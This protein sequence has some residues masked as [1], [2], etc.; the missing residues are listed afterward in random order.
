QTSDLIE[1]IIRK[2]RLT[3]A[4]L[5][6]VA[7]EELS[8]IVGSAATPLEPYLD[9]ILCQN[10]AASDFSIKDLMDAD[11]PV[12]LYYILPGTDIARLVPLTRMLII[13]MMRKLA[14]RMER[15]AS[16]A[17]KAP[18]RHRLLMMMD[19][20]PILG[21]IGEFQTSMAF[22]GGYG[23]KV[24]LIAQDLPQIMGAYGQYESI[25]GNC[26]IRIYFTPN[27]L[28]TA[29]PLS[30]SLGKTT[31]ITEQVTE[32][33]NRF[34]TV[35]GQVSRSYAETQRDLMTPDELLAM[36]QPIKTAD[37][38][39]I[40]E[41]GVILVSVAGRRPILAKQ[42]L[43]FLDPVLSERPRLEPPPGEQRAQPVPSFVPAPREAFVV[44]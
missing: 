29:E 26:H 23:I 18:H 6:S 9:P 10:T 13:T 14:P 37:G 32:S 38:T 5:V 4:R 42:S 7:D 16:G 15:D 35:L 41:P 31:V 34:G 40:I 3:G 25:I 22:L 11:D 39:R 2:V 30:R 43:W 20:F 33:G 19:E 1:S 27:R 36:A 21:K 44:Q 8:G 24:Y 17:V 28:E 12:S